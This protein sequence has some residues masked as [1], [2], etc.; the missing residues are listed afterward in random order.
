MLHLSPSWADHLDFL[1]D[2]FHFTAWNSRVHRQ[3]A[4]DGS[5]NSAA[6]LQ[7]RE[8][9]LDAEVH[10]VAMGDARFHPQAAIRPLFQAAQLAEL[11][12]D[13]FE[14]I[15]EGE[16]VEAR[17]DHAVRNLVCCADREGACGLFS[18]RRRR[19]RIHRAA[20]SQ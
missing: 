11:K 7:P 12:C 9:A 2:V 18:R 1:Y 3:P 19:Q 20:D 17:S 5:G 4:P 13:A 14:A 6:E 16:C 10:E 15:V 8:A